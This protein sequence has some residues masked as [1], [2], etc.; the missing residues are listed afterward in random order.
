MTKSE[1]IRKALLHTAVVVLWWAAIMFVGVLVGMAFGF[2]IDSILIRVFGFAVFV[3]AAVFYIEYRH[4]RENN[5]I[6][7]LNG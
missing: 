4:I 1:M 6:K 2:V 5:D 7:I 3:V